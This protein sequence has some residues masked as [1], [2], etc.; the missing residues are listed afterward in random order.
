MLVVVNSKDSHVRLLMNVMM[1]NVLLM[2][3]VFK[4]IQ[5]INAM[6]MINVPLT[7]A[8]AMKDATMKNTT[9]ILETNVYHSVVKL[10]KVANMRP[11]IVMIMML[12][13]LMTATLT[14]E[15]TILRLTVTI[16][17]NVLTIVVILLL[18]VLT[19][20]SIAMII[21][22]VLRILVALTKVVKILISL[23]T[24]TVH[25]PMTIAT[26]TL[27]ALISL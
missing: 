3:V 20:Q 25:V 17:L 19:L 16:T 14:L 2:K 6:R 13:L 9:V 5:V 18:A 12:A 4:L 10:K 7:L 1:Q 21:T 8:I 22:L 11:S 24:I 26:K 27:V 23:A 15:S